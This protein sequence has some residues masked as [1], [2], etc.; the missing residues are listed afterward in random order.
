MSARWGVRAGRPPGEGGRGG[1]P[2]RPRRRRGGAGRGGR[3]SGGGARRV[4]FPPRLVFVRGE[5]PGARGGKPK[6]RRAFPFSPPCP[7]GGGGG[8]GGGGARIRS[9]GFIAEPVKARVLAAEAVLRRAAGAGPHVLGGHDG[10]GHLTGAG[11]VRQTPAATRGRMGVCLRMG[12]GLGGQPRCMRSVGR[13][14][15]T[16]SVPACGREVPPLARRAAGGVRGGLVRESRWGWFEVAVAVAGR[17]SF[18]SQPRSVGLTPHFA[19]LPSQRD[20]RTFRGPLLPAASLQSRDRDPH[21]RGPRHDPRRRDGTPS[22]AA[23]SHP[24]HVAADEVRI[25]RLH[26]GGPADRAREDAL[27]EARGNRSSCASSAASASP[28]KP[29]GTWQ[30]AHAVCLPAGARDG[31]KSVC[32]ATST[33][34]RAAASPRQTAASA[35]AISSSVPPRRT[36]PRARTPPRAT[37]SG[38]RARSPPNAPG[39]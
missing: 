23:C 2:R 24:A 22:G 4:G 12:E 30:Y 17:G 11:A 5:G 34:G 15:P 7:W 3:R 31:S 26:R 16:A 13:A 8:G 39:P 36:V 10:R 32:C 33:Y 25:V 21:G 9:H 38:R 6:T 19:A 18:Q 35:A 37:G 1:A 14:V 27:A 20:T 29:F 28:A